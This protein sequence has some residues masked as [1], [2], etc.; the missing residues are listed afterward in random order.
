M[1]LGM[2]QGI[3]IHNNSFK[4]PS[5]SWIHSILESSPIPN[6]QFKRS[7]NVMNWW[8]YPVCEG[9]LGWKEGIWDIRS[10]IYFERMEWAFK[11]RSKHQRYDEHEYPNPYASTPHPQQNYILILDTWVS[12]HLGI[13][14][15]NP[16]WMGE[17]K[18]DFVFQAS[19][20]WTSLHGAAYII[21]LLLW[22]PG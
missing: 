17:C 3:E 2:N 14:S 16:Q 8:W 21:M 20:L 11:K 18:T 9:W 13:I 19:Y 7:P 12:R 5:D 6:S 10:M 1:P 15:W 22:Y 4:I